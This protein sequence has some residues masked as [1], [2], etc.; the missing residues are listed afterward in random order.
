MHVSLFD[1]PLIGF[2][3]ILSDR[4]FVYIPINIRWSIEQLKETQEEIIFFN[5]SDKK[6][7][8]N[9]LNRC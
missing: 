7:Y 5:E 2:K 3:F 8:E 4:E 6:I 9:I 1:L